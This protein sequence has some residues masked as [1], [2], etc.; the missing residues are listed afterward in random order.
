M[1]ALVK[2]SEGEVCLVTYYQNRISELTVEQLRLYPFAFNI[3][4]A[5]SDTFQEDSFLLYW[6]AEEG[7]QKCRTE[8]IKLKGI[9]V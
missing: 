3:M 1:S 8:L 7:I 5:P 2:P 9:I 4:D 6:V